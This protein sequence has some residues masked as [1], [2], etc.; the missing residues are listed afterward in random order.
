MGNSSSSAPRAPAGGP[1]LLQVLVSQALA[2]EAPVAQAPAPR[3]QDPREILGPAEV[4][5]ILERARSLRYPG[6]AGGLR[7]LAGL[8]DKRAAPF[9]VPVL[10]VFPN[11]S[12]PPAFARDDAEFARRLLAKLPELEGFD[13]KRHGLFLAGGC[14][15]ALLCRP[16]PRS[17][18]FGD[19]DFFLVGHADD[20]SRRAA[21]SAFGAHLAGRWAPAPCSLRRSRNAITFS[22]QGRPPFQ[23]V[24]R[25]YSTMAEVLHGFDLGSCSIGF[26]GSLVLLTELGALAAERGLNVLCL[27]GWR[28]SYER[29]LAKYAS[30][31]FSVVLPRLDLARIQRNSELGRN[32]LPFFSFYGADYSNWPRVTCW[33]FHAPSF[34]GPP[35]ACGDSYEGGMS[36][37]GNARTRNA[38]CILK[39]PP[40]LA[41]IEAVHPFEGPATLDLPAALSEGLLLLEADLR[42]RPASAGFMGPLRHY[43]DLPEAAAFVEEVKKRLLDLAAQYAEGF[44]F[45]LEFRGVDADTLLTP[46]ASRL[47]EDEWYG[48]AP[49]APAPV[50]GGGEA[51]AAQA[52]AAQAEKSEEASDQAC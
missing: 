25:G 21:I 22:T 46:E 2:P 49:Q 9:T 17:S 6:V 11:R 5:A 30:R 10:Q 40:R 7:G 28:S 44:H 29:R 42:A 14:A 24:L 12:D 16:E 43:G 34:G 32:V 51:S 39:S 3:A 45:P 8:T 52:S 47:S 26:D 19:A 35:E 1:T 37:R 31:G 27:D 36:A 50:A 15:A 20:L 41:G 23:V 33:G 38:L 48:F 4:N 13:L 18:D